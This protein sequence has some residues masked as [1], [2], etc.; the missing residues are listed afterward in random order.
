MP[1]S[2]QTTLSQIAAQYTALL[3]VPV[4]T[5]TIRK[6]IEEDPYYP[7]LFSLS[8][9][10]DKFNIEN[11]GYEVEPE[12]YGEL[13]APFIAYMNNQPNGKDFV[14]VT[15]IN[16]AGVVYQN[17]SKTVQASKEQFLREWQ[18]VVFMAAP[19]E[20]SGEADYAN[21][22]QQEKKQSFRTNLQAFAGILIFVLAAMFWLLSFSSTALAAPLTL[23]L[24]KSA[25]L[26]ATILLQVFEFNQHNSIVK[27]ICS[28]GKSTD[29]NAVLHSKA[30]TMF[31]IS[32][33]DAGFYYFAGSTLFLLFPSIPW[34]AK[35]PV[36]SLA[37]TLVALYIPFS[38]YY[39]WK[40]VKQW[41]PLCL[42]VQ[43]VL[44][45]ELVW[46]LF[47][48]WPEKNV[49]QE[50]ILHSSLPLLFSFLISVLLVPV[51]WPVVKKWMLQAR[52]QQSFEAAYKRLLYNPETFNNLLQQQPQAPE[53]Y[54]QIGITIGNP[55][56][57]NTILK[58]CNPYCG[59]CAS[60]HPVLEEIITGNPN[61]KVKVIFTVSNGADDVRTP[62]AKHLLA[63]AA[64]GD[65]KLTQQALDDWYLAP[66]KDYA[67]FAARYPMNGGLEDQHQHIAA[68]EKWCNDASIAYTP[69]LFINGYQ[70]PENYRI[71]ELKYIL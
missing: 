28:M 18:R 70:L 46:S 67:V 54:Q 5:T 13:T 55:E 12:H 11:G 71:E 22:L 69:T 30:A 41:C 63:I 29:C 24:I 50:F 64:L 21:K 52:E 66:K 48:F 3:K 65:P 2:F 19:N 26:A 60:L 10:F 68:M 20:Q 40:V 47:V 51:I 25:G 36:L 42:A 62:P 17:G 49:F 56:A 8:R 61:I 57:P 1:H 31:G 45:A 7:T 38:I 32:W 37:A 14:L 4:T 23:I 44:L 34:E 33:S 58:V 9:V 27:N 59:P 15:S 6:K 35:L 53:G 39:Q 43:A 16:D